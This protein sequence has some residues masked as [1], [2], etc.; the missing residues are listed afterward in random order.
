MS[1]NKDEH[2]C[3]HCKEVIPLNNVQQGNMHMG[4]YN[5]EIEVFKICL[6]GTC[7]FDE[8]LPENHNDYEINLVKMS[9]GEFY[10]L[11]EFEGF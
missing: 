11:P 6:D 4:C 2:R 7:Y 1:E 3:L 5:E 8:N 10:Y 9:R